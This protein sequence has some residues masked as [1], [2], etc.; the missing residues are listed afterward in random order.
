[1]HVEKSYHFQAPQAS[2]RVWK[3]RGLWPGGGRGGEPKARE[4]VTEFA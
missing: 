3:R 2:V 1:M 4:E